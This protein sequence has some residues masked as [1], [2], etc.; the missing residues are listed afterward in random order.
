MYLKV[1]IE[2]TTIK[3][4]FLGFLY[5]F[6]SKCYIKKSCNGGTSVTQLHDVKIRHLI[7][8]IIF[9]LTSMEWSIYTKVVTKCH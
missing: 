9:Y 7:L 2:L 4:N 6:K 1:G 3:F 5:D 8:R